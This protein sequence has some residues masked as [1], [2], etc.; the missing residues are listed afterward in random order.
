MRGMTHAEILNQIEAHCRAANIS[1][2]TFGL[3]AVNDGKLVERLRH[4]K[5]ITLGTL[6]RIKAALQAQTQQGAA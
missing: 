5:T 2:S 4:G 6:D 3:R 1:E